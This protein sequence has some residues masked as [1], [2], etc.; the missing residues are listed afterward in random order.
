[1]LLLAEGKN[2]CVG[3]D[4]KMFTDPA[5][6]SALVRD[7]CADFHVALAKLLGMRAPLVVAV[8]GHTVGAG[9]SL[10]AVADVLLSAESTQ[11]RIAYPTL[12]F[13][14][15]GGMTFTLPRLIGLRRFQ[16]LYFTNRAFSAAEA[17]AFGLVTRVVPDDALG[18]EASALAN[19]LASG[20]TLAFAGVRRLLL[21]TFAARPEAQLEAEARSLVEAVRSADV[22][23]GIAAARE[24]RAPKFIGA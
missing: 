6:Y 7:L 11:F 12:G 2:F 23:E 14:V 21:D 9:L 15:D 20:P 18:A 17:A 4:L 8:H 5:E 19:K 10:A 22:K 1:V 24:R 3:G 16:E 13:T